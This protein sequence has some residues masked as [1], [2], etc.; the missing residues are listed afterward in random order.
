MRC[1]NWRF[2]F[3]H[4]H[5]NIDLG[6]SQLLQNTHM[7]RRDHIGTSLSILTLT[8][9]SSFRTPTWPT[10]TT[11]VPAIN[12]YQS[13][14]C[15][16]FV[17]SLVLSSPNVE[18]QRFSV[19]RISSCPK[20]STLEVQPLD[21]NIQ[22]RHLFVGHLVSTDKSDEKYRHMAIKIKMLGQSSTQ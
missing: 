4:R 17:S 6:I 21:F 22:P 3:I 13:W 15:S 7:T 14:P 10:S 16:H 9:C 12:S 11:L 20:W 2:A 18:S 5:P 8:S 19:S 1:M